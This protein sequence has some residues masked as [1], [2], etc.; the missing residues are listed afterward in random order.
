MT[1]GEYLNP[2]SG[3]YTGVVDALS[4]GTWTAAKLSLPP[5]AGQDQEMELH[6]LTCPAAGTCVAVGS[7]YP[8]SGNIGWGLIQ[9][10][11]SGSWTPTEAPLPADAAAGDKGSGNLYGV[12]CTA[13]GACVA[14]GF[15][16][17]ADGQ[18][19]GLIETLANGVWTPTKAPL[20]PGAQGPWLDAV[21][22]VSPRSCVAVGYELGVGLIET[23]ANGT[24]HAAVAPRP[25]GA[26]SP[27]ELTGVA[28]PVSGFC[29]AVGYDGDNQ[30]GHGLIDT[31]VTGTWQAAVAPLPANAARTGQGSALS[32][33]ACAT[34]SY[35]VASGGYVDNNG[36]NQQLIETTS[37]STSP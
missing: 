4:R 31:L 28:C 10:L 1:A 7:I 22:C 6:A 16:T 5:D 34:V 15:Y 33:V 35:C 17:Q 30:N 3:Y 21:S 11:Q 18:S 8:S 27:E 2:S 26:Q 13:P 24:W 12:T 14:V 37:T 20:P 32:A 36:Q 25:K 19:Q 9:T 29:V 23:L